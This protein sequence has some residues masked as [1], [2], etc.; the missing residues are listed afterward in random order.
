M[1]K[2]YYLKESR[3]GLGGCKLIAVVSASE[4]TDIVL[5]TISTKWGT[6]ERI[7]E[8]MK[9]GKSVFKD[10][11]WFDMT[12]VKHSSPVIKAGDSETIYDI[13]DIVSKNLV[14]P[15]EMYQDKGIQVV[16]KKDSFI[17][18]D[19]LREADK[20]AGSIRVVFGETVSGIPEEGMLRP[21]LKTLCGCCGE[22]FGNNPVYNNYGSVK[23][24]H[25]K[26]MP[27]NEIIDK[28]LKN[29][30]EKYF[31]RDRY[32]SNMRTIFF[33]KKHSIKQYY[34]YIE[35]LENGF[36]IS[37]IHL[38]MDI[39]DGVLKKKWSVP[40][41]LTHDIGTQIAAYKNSGKKSELCDP[42]EAMLLKKNVYVDNIYASYDNFVDMMLNNE[43]QMRMCGFMDVMKTHNIFNTELFFIKCLCVFNKYPSMEQLVKAG[44]IKFFN[45]IMLML[46]SIG[47]EK[48]IE[49]Y[50]K[51]FDGIINRDS[52]TSQD[53]LK[54]P[55]YIMEW[56]QLKNANIKEYIAWVDIFGMTNFTKEQ[57]EQT[58]D[59]YEFAYVYSE[60]NAQVLAD[61]L[62][63]GYPLNK[64]C[65]Y[66]AKEAAKGNTST[67]GAL[68]TL[69]D[70][71]DM[72]DEL[73]IEP[74][75]YPMDLEGQHR[76]VLDALAVKETGADDNVIA[77]IA[78]KCEAWFE[79]HK[80][81][82]GRPDVFDD[83]VVVFPKSSKDFVEEG[84]NQHNCVAHYAKSAVARKC[85]IYFLRKKDT[86]S[87][88]FI[89]GEYQG[90]TR[91]FYF[92]HNR[93]VESAELL[94]I[95]DYINSLLSTGIEEGAI[96][97]LD[98]T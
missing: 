39:E 22:T 64:L 97:G 54:I 20:R 71:L 74:D 52:A 33:T 11:K 55:K 58:I 90:Y 16:E 21:Y 66:L 83:Y 65:R 18:D 43:K 10:W 89:T 4:D 62:K 82:E 12:C 81:A 68:D 8:D 84:T 94:D 77:E 50:M 51:Q 24:P 32:G 42:I 47:S 17:T 60:I 46:E 86:P 59:S 37:I 95:R 26:N 1:N 25:C 67:V 63:R 7:I 75:M 70:Y 79:K 69:L 28:N 73:G 31:E 6:A 5:E 49:Q 19:M 85:I 98:L 92:A 72:C 38:Q 48:Q 61:A 9:N 27:A 23:C 78:E 96:D 88:S 93:S 2:K 30:R 29:N 41:V 53:V 14:P 87:K 57:F 56:L 91:Q 35:V 3:V 36:R 40:Y 76:D 45:E 34:R 15:F 44:G 80:D 13:T